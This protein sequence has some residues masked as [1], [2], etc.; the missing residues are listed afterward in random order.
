MF[1]I[2]RNFQ[3]FSS[4]MWYHITFS[5]S[6][7]WVI[8]FFHVPASSW[9]CLSF[10]FNNTDRCIVISYWALICISLTENDIEYLFMCLFH[11]CVPFSVKYIFMLSSHFL[12]R[13][14]ICFTVV[15]WEFLILNTSLLSD[16][17]QIFSSILYLVFLSFQ[18]RLLTNCGFSYCTF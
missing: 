15:F 16:N 17:L 6:T 9:W 4:N 11:I 18:Q 2:L 13:L 12:I 3:L 5:N 10:Y 7:V 1:N 14:Y 8:L